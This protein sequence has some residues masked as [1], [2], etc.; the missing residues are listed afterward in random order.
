LTILN[1]N[2][3]S[4]RTGRLRQALPYPAYAR[5]AIHRPSELLFRCNREIPRSRDAPHPDAHPP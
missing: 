3:L 4:V 2:K 1:Q 5:Y